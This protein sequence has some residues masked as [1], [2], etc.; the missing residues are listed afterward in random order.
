MK[1]KREKEIFHEKVAELVDVLIVGLEDRLEAAHNLEI[2]SC[3]IFLDL[4]YLKVLQ[5]IAYC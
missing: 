4:E 5:L 2:L 3:G 1:E